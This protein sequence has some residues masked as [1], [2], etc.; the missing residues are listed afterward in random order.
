[1]CFFASTLNNKLSYC[2]LSLP[3]GLAQQE[4]V[5]TCGM[6]RP[7]ALVQCVCSWV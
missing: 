3:L 4:A 5:G 7:G 6:M 2:L 1:M